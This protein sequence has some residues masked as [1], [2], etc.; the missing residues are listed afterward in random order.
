MNGD[1]AEPVSF[2]LPADDPELLQQCVVTTFRASGKGGQHVNKTDSAV[3]LRHLPTGITVICRRERSQYLNKK[4]ALARLRIKI[5]ALLDRPDERKPTNVP[6]S[7]KRKRRQVKQY[8]SARKKL[9]RTPAID[10]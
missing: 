6:L 4:I 1:A 7:E 8:H 2:A 5:A 9:R 3:R 10:E